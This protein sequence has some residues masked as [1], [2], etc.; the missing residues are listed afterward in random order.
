MEK[1]TYIVTM[2][3]STYPEKTMTDTIEMDS[4]DIYEAG[5]DAFLR[6]LARRA[7]VRGGFR[8]DDRLR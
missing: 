7:E 1:R 2:A 3:C 6:T 4:D 5:I 8:A